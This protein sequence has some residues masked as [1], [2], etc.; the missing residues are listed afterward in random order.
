MPDVAQSP[1]SSTR[2][3]PDGA[4]RLP[5]P[6]RQT[7]VLLVEDE[8]TI[9]EVFL[10]ALRDAGFSAHLAKDGIQALH[11]LRDRAPD[12]IVLDVS[13]PTLSGVEILRRLRA[14]ERALLPVLVVSGTDRAATRIDDALLRPG[15]WLTKPL[16]PRELVA[17][18]R[19]L[20]DGSEPGRGDSGPG[21]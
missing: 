16:R 11:A 17:A 1:N 15:R 12:L 5:R 4:G 19:E 14:S 2:G 8:P 7:L 3:A 13:L 21:P 6:A 20:V 10:R 18:V 9:A